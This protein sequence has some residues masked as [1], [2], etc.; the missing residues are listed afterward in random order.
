M[1]KLSRNGKNLNL[2][3]KEKSKMIINFLDEENE[4]F[5]DIYDIYDVFI[6]YNLI[7]FIFLWFG[8]KHNRYHSLNIKF[9]VKSV[10]KKLFT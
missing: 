10:N 2:K 3:N 5:Y 7:L 9:I 4:K 8:V 1:K 6:S